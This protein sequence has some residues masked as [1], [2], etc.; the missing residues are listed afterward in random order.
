MWRVVLVFKARVLPASMLLQPY[1]SKGCFSL[2]TFN[3]VSHTVPDEGPDED[4][5]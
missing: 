2:M 3:Q 5:H 1:W 4:S